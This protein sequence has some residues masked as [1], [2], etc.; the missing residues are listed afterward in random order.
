[1]TKIKR[2]VAMTFT[3]YVANAG[4][5]LGLCLGFSFISGIE[6]IFWL[7]CC[8]REVI[9]LLTKPQTDPQMDSTINP[10]KDHEPNCSKGLPQT[11]QC[12]MDPGMDH[13]RPQN[14][15]SIGSPK[16]SQIKFY[17]MPIPNSH[18][19]NSKKF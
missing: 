14:K 1:M 6:I 16:G 7:C 9:S 2:D 10:L 11:D 3:S 19:N 4:G 15:P 12:Q 8:F 17:T 13:K 5:L 18:S